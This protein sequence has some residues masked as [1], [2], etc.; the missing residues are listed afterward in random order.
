MAEYIE[1]VDRTLIHRAYLIREEAKRR[2]TR[3]TIV[4]IV[5]DLLNDVLTDGNLEALTERFCKEK[6]CPS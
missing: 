4:K 1:G 2:G 5:N 6:R 3:V